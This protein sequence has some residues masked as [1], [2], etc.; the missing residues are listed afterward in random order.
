MARNPDETHWVSSLLQEYF[1][2]VDGHWIQP[3]VEAELALAA[4]V[5]A[6]NSHN[7]KGG[8]RPRKRVPSH[9]TQSV[10]SGFPNVTQNNP[11]PLIH[12]STTKALNLSVETPTEVSEIDPENPPKP[13]RQPPRTH[14]RF[15]DFWHAYPT[16]VAKPQ[17]LE[18]WKVHNLD[19]IADDLIADVNAK[20]KRDKRWLDGYAPNPL[21]YLNQRRWD[22]PIQTVVAANGRAVDETPRPFFRA[23]DPNDPTGEA[24]AVPADRERSRAAIEE[25]S[26]KLRMTP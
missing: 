5:A 13:K 23:F 7:G 14:A 22:D 8:G 10:S 20:R 3:R 15:D 6:R 12:Q 17:C 9:K 1:Q 25:L 16:K 26:K 4:S 18:K 11:N 2:E 21:T 24:D 19:L